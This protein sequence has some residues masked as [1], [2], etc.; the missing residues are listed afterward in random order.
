[1]NGV[2]SNKSLLRKTTPCVD[3]VN[4]GPVR[5]A[6]DSTFPLKPIGESGISR[7]GAS[8]RWWQ[9]AARGRGAA[10]WRTAG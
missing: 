7:D 3:I 9:I 1:M 2:I 8:H 5:D 10:R 4:K 6:T